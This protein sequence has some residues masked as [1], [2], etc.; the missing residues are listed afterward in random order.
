VDAARAD[1]RSD[2][3]A[4]KVDGRSDLVAVKAD[5][6]SDQVVVKADGRSDRRGLKVEIALDVP[7]GM[8]PES[9]STRGFFGPGRVCPGRSC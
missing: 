2:P 5:D 4:V 8:M 1:G 7:V 6:H 3:V 9:D